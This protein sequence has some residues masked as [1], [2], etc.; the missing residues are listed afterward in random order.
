L[1][2]LYSRLPASSTSNETRKQLQLRREVVKL[3][4]ELNATSSQ[5]E[6]AKWAKIRR[7]HDKKVAEY[8]ELC[9]ASQPRPLAQ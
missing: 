9:K 3:K 4:R 1:W 5:D 6:F 2:T 8:D 7:Q